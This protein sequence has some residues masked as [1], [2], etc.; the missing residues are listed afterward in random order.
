MY[1]QFRR[2]HTHSL[3]ASDLLPAALAL[4]KCYE[5]IADAANGHD[6]PRE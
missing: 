1:K 5:F 2:E 6:D 4:T 3:R